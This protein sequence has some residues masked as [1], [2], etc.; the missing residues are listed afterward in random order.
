M[1]DDFHNLYE[2]TKMLQLVLKPALKAFVLSS[3]MS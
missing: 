1:Y 3:A 2:H